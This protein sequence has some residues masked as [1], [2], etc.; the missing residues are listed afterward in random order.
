VKLLILGVGSPFGQDSLGWQ[1]IDGLIECGLRQRLAPHEVLLEK[2]DRP[3]TLLLE[4]MRGM[5]AAIL[6]DALIGGDEPGQVHCLSVEE[7]A[8]GGLALSGHDLG[9]AEAL[10][11][12]DALG[13]LPEKVLVLGVEV[14]APEGCAP[15]SPSPRLGNQPLDELVNQILEAVP[16][17]CAP[18]P[19][20]G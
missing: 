4:H 3:G 9:V 14:T 15:G 6:I 8:Q 11:L 2:A 18:Q 7:V 12:G 13:D 16:A 1:A 20:P 5:D 17:I 19:A 10:A